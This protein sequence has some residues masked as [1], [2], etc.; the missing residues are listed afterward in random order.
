MGAMP[1]C[2][3]GVWLY[4]NA[5]CETAKG[6]RDLSLMN[7][8]NA[9]EFIQE[10]LGVVKDIFKDIDQNHP[11]HIMVT[12]IVAFGPYYTARHIFAIKSNESDIPISNIDMAFCRKWQQN[13]R[14]VVL[15]TTDKEI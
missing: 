9:Q 7:V 1:V 6:H 3:L 13:M 14:K 2:C 11:G 15:E 12:T 8:K 10:S 5:E 4:R